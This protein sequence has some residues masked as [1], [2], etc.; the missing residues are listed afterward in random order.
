MKAVCDFC[1]LANAQANSASSRF[2]DIPIYQTESLAL[3]PA[4]GPMALGHV[5]VVTKRHLRNFSRCN[6]K[7]Q[8]E[9][10]AIIEH[11]G[12]VWPFSSSGILQIECGCGQ[13]FS[14]S[15]CITHAHIG[16]IPYDPNYRL[17]L[18]CELPTHSEISGVRDLRSDSRP[19]IYIESP[20]WTICYDGTSAEPQFIRKLIFSANGRTDW[21]WNSFPNLEQIRDTVK[22]FSEERSG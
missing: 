1:A 10:D 20:E 6:D 13:F 15:A 17:L 16:L 14:G 12:A 7:E 8:R 19:Y 18:D 9:L 5:L 3:L 21:D 4:V 22:L 11:V 2:Y